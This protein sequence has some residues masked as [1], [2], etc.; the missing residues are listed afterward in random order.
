MQTLWKKRPINL[1]SIIII[2]H[3]VKLKFIQ[4]GPMKR[5]YSSNKTSPFC[6]L[7]FRKSY[8]KIS[9]WIHEAMENQ[10]TLENAIDLKTSVMI[11]IWF[12]K[13]LCDF[14]KERFSLRLFHFIR[15]THSQAMIVMNILKGKSKQ[16]QHQKFHKPKFFNV[17]NGL[18]NMH[19]IYIESKF[20][21]IRIVRLNGQA[22]S[23]SQNAKEN[24][25]R[26]VK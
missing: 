3:L 22:K 8:V 1:I 5:K 14:N 24:H 2:Q 15:G 4:K 6:S 21:L 10:Q 25:R 17:M 16:Q 12:M 13:T 20:V 11:D 19:S 9:I 26:N 18:V 23:G 7:N